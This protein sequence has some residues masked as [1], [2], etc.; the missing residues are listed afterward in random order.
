[1][2]Y[3]DRRQEDCPVKF[4][5]TECTGVTIGFILAEK[6]ISTAPRIGGSNAF[7]AEIKEAAAATKAI[8]K[9]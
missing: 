8:G 6:E 9:E 1:M 4:S 2:E 7:P 3:V 5:G